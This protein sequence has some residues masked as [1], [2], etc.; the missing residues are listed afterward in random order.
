MVHEMIGMEER[1]DFILHLETSNW[2]GKPREARNINSYY[3]TLYF[4]KSPI[5]DC[6]TGA[7][8]ASMS[9]LPTTSENI[10]KPQIV[11]WRSTAN[12]YPSI[13]QMELDVSYH[14]S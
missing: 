9:Q 6:L 2:P 7:E 14:Q 11:I 8:S 5:W 12:Q 1:K 4:R 13:A 3:P 10:Q